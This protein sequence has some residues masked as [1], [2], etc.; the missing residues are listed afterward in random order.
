M[1]P[2]T[3]QLSTFSKQSGPLIATWGKLARA[4]RSS[5]SFVRS[6]RTATD[7]FGSWLVITN[8]SELAE[9][10]AAYTN[11]HHNLLHGA[12]GHNF[13]RQ[14]QNHAQRRHPSSRTNSR[15]L[16]STTNHRKMLLLFSSSCKSLT[17]RC[18]SHG[19]ANIERSGKE[20]HQMFVVVC[21]ALGGPSLGT[22]P[23]VMTYR[24][25]E[26]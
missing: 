20:M 26:S 19:L 17:R 12:L 10:L 3:V 16:P 22:C 7:C 2:Q 21:N 11:H 6:I 1:G 25:P 4:P 13:Q 15:S 8:S 9:L 14:L 24:V 18:D 5:L 23:P